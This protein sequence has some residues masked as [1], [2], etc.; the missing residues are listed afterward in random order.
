MSLTAQSGSAA[1]NTSSSLSS[2]GT[3]SSMETIPVQDDV[4]VDYQGTLGSLEIKTWGKLFPISDAFKVE[5]LLDS[6]DRYVFGRDASCDVC[7][8]TPELSKLP[9]FGTISKTHFIIDKEVKDDATFVFI[10]DKSSNG[11]FVN[12]EK[13]GRGKKRILNNNDEIAL[14]IPQNKVYVFVDTCMCEEEQKIM[15]A[16]M[17]AKY[18]LSKQ[19]GR[20]ACGVVKLAFEKDSCQKVA[21]KII[22]KKTFSMGGTMM[23]NMDKAVMEEV[24]ILKAL[25]HPCIIKIED[26]YETEERLFIVLELVEGGELF[27][28]VSSRG[29]FSEDTAKVMFY[30]ILVACKYL[31]DNKISHR[32]LKP[33]NILLVNDKTETLVK[34]TDFGLSKF[35]GEVSFM[36]TQCGT[37]TYL[38]PEIVAGGGISRYGRAV[39]CWSLGVILFICLGG[40]PP[41]SEEIKIMPLNDQIKRGYYSFPDKYW[42]GI[43]DDAK[44]LI[45]RLLTVDPQ[46]R[47]TTTK[48]LQHSWLSNPDIKRR[49]EQLMHPN[50]INN[51]MPP[52]AVPGKKR[53]REDENDKGDDENYPDSS[54]NGRKMS[55][56]SS[57]SSSYESDDTRPA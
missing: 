8:N 5:E 34:V 41:F 23:K 21:I 2:A 33:E 26:V 25:N 19:L 51:N 22:E 40:Y 24:R 30:Q 35:V 13:V 47:L 38:A 7:F 20:G 3:V 52:P 49:A 31:H 17:K 39:D 6:S 12:G 48:A 16:E 42:S 45:K 43:S 37:P 18:I 1:H 50:I 11:T 28:R 15:P 55:T 57:R 46:R 4:D 14:S 36:K 32:D 54:E 53:L 10:E 29:K 56:K 44:D 27:D 9:T